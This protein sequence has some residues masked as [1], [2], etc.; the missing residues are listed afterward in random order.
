MSTPTKDSTAPG[1]SHPIAVA[2][3]PKNR[4]REFALELTSKDLATISAD[5]DILDLKKLKFLGELAYNDQGEVVL[6]ANLGATATQAC[7]I[8]LEP[9]RTRIDAQI[10]SRFSPHLDQTE[11][12][13]QM[14]PEDDENIDPLEQAIDLGLVLTEAIA[15]NLPDF[16]RSEGAELAQRT[17]AE[18]GVTP[19]ENKDTKPFAS[20]AALKDKLSSDD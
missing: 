11:E 7:V 17:F 16:P 15:L 5:L 8:T 2:D 1:F 4:A 13:Q 3:L 18:P 6:N 12:E 10:T 9:V 19:L 14:L 20:L